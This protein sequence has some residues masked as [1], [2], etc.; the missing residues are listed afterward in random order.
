M[1]EESTQWKTG[2]L[3]TPLARSTSSRPFYFSSCLRSF[4][5]R[6]GRHSLADYT[7]LLYRCNRMSEGEDEEE[8]EVEEN[9]G[10]ESEEKVG[11]KY[12]AET[13]SHGPQKRLGLRCAERVDVKQVGFV[14]Y[15]YSTNRLLPNL[16]RLKARLQCGTFS[17]SK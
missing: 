17:I 14:K 15:R 5:G 1:E 11:K 8:E 16:Y 3:A 2:Q 13:K 12:K 7:G 4:V 9:K 6:D 10:D